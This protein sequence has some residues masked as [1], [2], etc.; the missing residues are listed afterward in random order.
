MILKE[1]KLENYGIFHNKDILI[2]D[3]NLVLLYGLNEAGKTTILNAI[4]ESFFGF[5]QNKNPYDFGAGKMASEVNL[6]MNNGEEIYYRRTKARKDPVNGEITLPNGGSSI[7]LN[8]GKLLEM[9][10]NINNEVYWNLFGFSSAELAQGEE[11]IKN[12]EITE[13]LYGSGMG[14]V[15]NIEDIR[16]MIVS[17]EEGLF[18]STGKHPFLNK[19]IKQIDEGEKEMR[20][21]I[22][23]P[24]NYDGRVREL[25]KK[26][27]IKDELEQKREEA[28]RKMGHFEIL[29]EAQEPF[30]N[31]KNDKENLDN[32]SIPQNI[33]HDMKNKYESANKELI[34]LDKE[35]KRLRNELQDLERKR[36]KISF[37]KELIEEK[38]VLE[39]LF[40]EVKRIEAYHKDIPEIGTQSKMLQQEITDAL[41]N[42][43][44]KW[45]MDF[46]KSF[47]ADITVRNGFD[48]LIK[49]YRE[50]TNK[51][52]KVDDLIEQLQTEIEDKENILT[53]EGEE[54]DTKVF[55]ELLEGARDYISKKEDYEQLLE[56]KEKLDKNV[57][58]IWKELAPLIKEGDNIDHPIP[59]NKTITKYEKDLE[60]MNTDLDKQKHELESQER[61]AISDQEDL[62]A[63]VETKDT[64]DREDLSRNR[65][66]R[67]KGW[68]LIKKEYIQDGKKVS[69]KEK[70]EWMDNKHTELPDAYEEAVKES[71]KISDELYTNSEMVTKKEDLEKR[72]RK[73]E[74]LISDTRKRI[75]RIEKKIA[76]TTSKWNDE[77]KDW[78]FTSRSPREMKEWVSSLKSLLQL[79]DDKSHIEDQMTELKKKHNEFLKEARAHYKKL[80]EKNMTATMKKVDQEIKETRDS[81]TR[82]KQLQKDIKKLKK[83]QTKKVA[84]QKNLKKK[85]DEW[86]K[87]WSALLK[88]VNFNTEWDTEI[89]DKVLK[90][91]FV[92]KQKMGEDK[93]N[94]ERLKDMNDT[95][96]EYLQKVEDLTNRLNWNRMDRKNPERTVKELY[97][98]VS[99]EQKKAQERKGLEDKI[100][101]KKVDIDRAEIE[102][103]DHEKII[104]DLF[105]QVCVNNEG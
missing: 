48:N 74:A 24:F 12:K 30:L 89:A 13:V 103:K 102:R 75:S 95:V 22:I 16:S 92:S 10:G 65:D 58:G 91:L 55:E 68:E 6:I 96:A 81:N 42:I 31:I 25:R 67:D 36:D 104:N 46:L 32:I 69:S 61:T 93:E 77:W 43:D 8:E 23:L 59:L 29:I 79:L 57:N 83:E 37:S 27:K 80:T 15:T 101:D 39:T 86:K 51:I 14:G 62:D 21:K 64:V 34:R 70:Q 19:L 82:I 60:K 78:G 18:K 4:R 90:E 5:K 20:G 40:S 41:K 105:T 38:T 84:E 3:G 35:L 56:E 17:E 66:H 63:M 2:P 87:K 97:S 53:E 98:K 85:D 7:E 71:D 47:N 28:R 52:E 94:H 26:E 54:K 44:S 49:E 88:K 99:E 72:I 33:P 76:D 45:D 73:Q 50:L 9:F 11:S 1:L 100:E